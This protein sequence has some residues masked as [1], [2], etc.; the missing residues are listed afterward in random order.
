MDTVVSP[1]PNFNK[2]DAM[3][4]SALIATGVRLRAKP[5]KGEV[6]LSPIVYLMY[7]S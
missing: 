4:K 2:I 6:P 5:S 3:D 1:F 7:A